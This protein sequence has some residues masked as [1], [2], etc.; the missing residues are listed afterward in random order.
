MYNTESLVIA[1]ESFVS[2]TDRS[3]LAENCCLLL[4][5][6][7]RSLKDHVPVEAGP[8][9]ARAIVFARVQSVEKS[10]NSVRVW[11]SCEPLMLIDSDPWDPLCLL[12]FLCECH[13]RVCV[14]HLFSSGGW[15][16]LGEPAVYEDT[17]QRTLHE[18]EWRR[19]PI[20]LKTGLK[21][22]GVYTLLGERDI[23]RAAVSLVVCFEGGGLQTDLDI[24]TSEA[25]RANR[26]DVRLLERAFLLDNFQLLISSDLAARP[27]DPLAGDPFE[28]TAAVRIWMKRTIEV[29]ANNALLLRLDEW[30]VCCMLETG[31]IGMATGERGGVPQEH[32][33]AAAA[34]VAQKVKPDEEYRRIMAM[35]KKNAEHKENAYVCF[36]A[37]LEQHFS[38]D[39]ATRCLVAR[40]NPTVALRKIRMY[41]QVANAKTPPLVVQRKEGRAT[42]ISYYGRVECDSPEQ[43]L[44][45]WMSIVDAHLAGAYTRKANVFDIIERITKPPQKPQDNEQEEIGGARIAL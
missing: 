19:T 7:Q 43:A 3:I 45:A 6:S 21:A 40:L 11:T 28:H 26:L 29:D 9:L 15:E 39:W 38:F 12:L 30:A 37:M 5:V 41:S 34:W 27:L 33:N 13:L 2:D 18:D 42:V 8:A 17:V 14:T 25:P 4:A 20:E 36:A 35:S 16:T 23:A 1:C 10:V 24:G 22:R 31:D 44:S 32:R